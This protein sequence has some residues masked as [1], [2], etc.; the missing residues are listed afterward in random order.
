ME[1]EGEPQDHSSFPEEVIDYINNIDM[2]WNTYTRRMC[3]L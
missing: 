1:K 2:F 3:I